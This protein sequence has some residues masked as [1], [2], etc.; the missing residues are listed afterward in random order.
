MKSLDDLP[1]IRELLQEITMEVPFDDAQIESRFS[2]RV[3]WKEA[4]RNLNGVKIIECP[5]VVRLEAECKGYAMTNL[6]SSPNYLG[7]RH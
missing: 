7:C 2:C 5:D 3:W 4:I 1:R 6:A